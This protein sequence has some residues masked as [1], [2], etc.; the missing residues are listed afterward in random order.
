MADL[1]AGFLLS[2]GVLAA[3][4]RARDTGV[5]ERVEVSLLAA[6]LAV[7]IQDLVW[8]EGEATND[9]AV[10]ATRADLSERATE[11][12]TGL[13]M[14]P[15]YRCYAA[16]DGFLAVACLN[17]VQRRAFIAVFG[18]DDP[19]IEAPDLVP[20]D[21]VLLQHKRGIVATVEERIAGSSVAAWLDRFEA[22]GVPCG[23]VLTREGV[24]AD[25]QVR[26]NHLV[27]E[28]VQPGLGPVTMLGRVFGTGDAAGIGPAP[29][30]GADTDA[31][32]AELE[33][34]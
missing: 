27:E 6:A 25:V 16:A 10:V 1:T 3:L 5:G 22:A 31:V 15:Y 19:T 33:T 21:E 12:A 17:L 23:P 4:V 34:L 7:Q 9:E 8:L 18:L 11:I 2:T 32:L 30:L 13:A 14:N 29:V 26:A 20:A 28:V 24:H